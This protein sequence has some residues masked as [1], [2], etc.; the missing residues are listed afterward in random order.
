[1]KDVI[2][3]TDEVVIVILKTRLTLET[4][5]VSRLAICE[6]GGVEVW[7]NALRPS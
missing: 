5:K 7:R 6:R 4:C 2:C 3:H 1:M